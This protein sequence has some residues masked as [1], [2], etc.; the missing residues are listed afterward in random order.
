MDVSVVYAGLLGN[1]LMKSLPSS[2]LLASWGSRGS[3]PKRVPQP[4]QLLPNA[5]GEDIGALSAVHAGEAGHVL[6]NAYYLQ[7]SLPTAGQVPPHI[8]N[9]NHL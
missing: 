4:G 2:K 3:E 5:S 9:S 1:S 7:P 8:P 6:Y